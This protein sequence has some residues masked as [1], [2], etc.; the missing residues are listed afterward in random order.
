MSYI[1]LH[2]VLRDEVNGDNYT[3]EVKNSLTAIEHFRLHE[4]IMSLTN[5]HHTVDHSKAIEFIHTHGI[6]RHFIRTDG[7]S[8]TT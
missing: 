4:L 6:N 1:G 5:N 3:L 2:I 8:P 7:V